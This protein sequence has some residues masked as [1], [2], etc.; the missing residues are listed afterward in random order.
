MFDFQVDA[1]EFYSEE[2]ARLALQVEN[3]KVHALQRPTG[4]AFLTFDSVESANKVLNDHRHA[5]QCLR[6]IPTSSVSAEL[7]P[8]NWFV[9]VAPYPEDIYWWVVFICH[10]ERNTQNF[11]S[12]AGTVTPTNSNSPPP[13]SEIQGLTV[14]YIG[15]EVYSVILSMY[16]CK[17][18][19]LN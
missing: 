2:E 10:Q 12:L 7:K 16:C 1:I 14:P 11:L 5:C 19:S 4:V 6:D 8:Y 15:S 17:V 13:P 18:S 9:R 3:E